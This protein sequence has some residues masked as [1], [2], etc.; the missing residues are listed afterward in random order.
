MG[1]AEQR[2]GCQE[3]AVWEQE[4]HTNFSLMIAMFSNTGVTLKSAI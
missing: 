2:K 3:N 4:T 1:E